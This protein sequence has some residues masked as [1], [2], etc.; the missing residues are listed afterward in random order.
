MKSVRWLLPL[1]LVALVIRTR[2]ATWLPPTVAEASDAF[3]SLLLPLSDFHDSR[4]FSG[5]CGSLAAVVICGAFFG[6]MSR[7]PFLAGACVALLAPLSIAASREAGPG[8]PLALAF[9]LLCLLLISP[10][11]KVP[12]RIVVGV[13][14]AAFIALAIPADRAAVAAL[15]MD[16]TARLWFSTCGFIAGTACLLLHHVGYAAVPLALAGIATREGRRVAVL[17]P[18]A[19]VAALWLDGGELHRLSALAAVSPVAV[20]LL[21]LF[22]ERAA[23]TDSESSRSPLGAAALSALVIAVNLPVLVSDVKSGQR[24][25]W[26]PALQRL[27]ALDPPLA[28]T[29]PIYTTT[30]PPVAWLTERPVLPLPDDPAE[31]ETLLETTRPLVV[32]L[33]VEGGVAYG[34]EETGLLE[35]LEARGLPAFESRVKRFDLYRFEVQGYVWR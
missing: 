24:F 3:R 19:I 20:S 5:L 30:T 21:W 34:A 9:A 14:A 35:T 12:V 1:F 8:G 27:K 26:P 11:R 31:L 6:R 32:L 10:P 16:P 17:L 15:P 18:L 25:P 29:T 33:P 4:L 22:L 28:E 23:R 13:L 2:G 7:L